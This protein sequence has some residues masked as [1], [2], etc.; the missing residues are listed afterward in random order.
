MNAYW[1][2]FSSGLTDQYHSGGA[3]VVCAESEKAAREIVEAKFQN[4]RT[5]STQVCKSS[6]VIGSD[7]IVFRDAGCC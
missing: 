7:P 1:F 6:G 2:T 4:A 5:S 3:V